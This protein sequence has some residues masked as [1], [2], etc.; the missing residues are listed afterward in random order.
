M[1]R[2]ADVE[3][4]LMNEIDNQHG[5]TYISKAIHGARMNVLLIIWPD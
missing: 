1:E 4:V 3:K 5:A 2:I